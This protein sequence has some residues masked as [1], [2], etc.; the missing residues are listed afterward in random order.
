MRLCH[1]PDLSTSPKYKLLCFKHHNLFYQNIECTSFKPGYE[2]PFSALFMVASFPLCGYIPWEGGCMQVLS[3]LVPSSQTEGLLLRTPGWKNWLEKFGIKWAHWIH[4]NG[5]ID[6][7]D[8]NQTH[9]AKW[10]I[11]QSMIWPAR[12]QA[13]RGTVRGDPFQPI[14]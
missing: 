1:P 2:L 6:S 8:I 9:S 10:Y 5:K 4:F 14:L 3:G 12:L 7:T 13:Y 11:W